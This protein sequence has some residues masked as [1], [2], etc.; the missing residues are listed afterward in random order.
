MK[1]ELKVAQRQFRKKME[2]K[3]WQNEINGVWKEQ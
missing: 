1:D 3:L 2:E